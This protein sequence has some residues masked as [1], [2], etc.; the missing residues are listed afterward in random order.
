MVRVAVTWSDVSGSFLRD[1]GNCGLS[2]VAAL[3]CLRFPEG[4]NRVQSIP[5][6]VL[7]LWD[8][9]VWFPGTRPLHTRDVTLSGHDAR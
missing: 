2:S 1:G 4:T 6:R 7:L 9:C 8:S 5:R 3:R